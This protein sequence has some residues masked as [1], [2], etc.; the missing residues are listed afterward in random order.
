MLLFFKAEEG[1]LV[2]EP[3][4]DILHKLTPRHVGLQVPNEGV[5]HEEHLGLAAAFATV[6]ADIG[7]VFR[8]VVANGEDEV[9]GLFV[10]LRIHCVEFDQ[11]VDMD[12][13]NAKV[14]EA[15]HV[16][17]QAV[18][19]IDG[20]IT[21]MGVALGKQQER[22]S[23]FHAL[24]PFRHLHMG[25]VDGGHQRVVVCCCVDG[26]GGSGLVVG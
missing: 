20:G 14:V 24:V 16:A 9:E 26:I 8:R 2:V 3:D 10:V 1:R 12:V 19:A 18:V 17:K 4:F 22:G 25:E 15:V 13:G 21:P 11:P 7:A 23:V 6:D 5:A